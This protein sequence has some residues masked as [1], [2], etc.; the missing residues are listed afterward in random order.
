MC[1]VSAEK[2][3]LLPQQDASCKILV[4]TF[5]VSIDP[6]SLDWQVVPEVRRDA[7]PSELV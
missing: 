3:V 2:L 4:A 5:T 7:A 1:T 6:L